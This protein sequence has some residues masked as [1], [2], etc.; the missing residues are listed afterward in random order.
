M[1][2]SVSHF[3]CR[4]VFDDDVSTTHSTDTC[5]VGGSSGGVWLIGTDLSHL[6]QVNRTSE[7]VNV[8]EGYFRT[9]S[10]LF[11]ESFVF[12]STYES[13][14]VSIDVCRSASCAHSD[15]SGR[16]VPTDRSTRAVHRRVVVIALRIDTASFESCFKTS[17]AL[18]LES[19]G[20][21]GC[22]VRG[23][24]CPPSQD[25]SCLWP[26]PTRT[27]RDPRCGRTTGADELRVL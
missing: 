20:G 11:A 7:Q 3:P 14:V 15:W 23:V 1:Q 19:A 26:A 18:S 16:R 27:R 21:V 9:S 17:R 22:R 8:V 13:W 24:I 5:F 10:M 2:G 4:F 6:G 12:R 25:W